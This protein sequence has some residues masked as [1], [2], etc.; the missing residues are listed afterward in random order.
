MKTILAVLVAA[1]SLT[2]QEANKT[3][4][5]MQ[6]I[7]KGLAD[8]KS[9][10]ARTRRAAVLLLGKYSQ[11]PAV[12]AVCD[13]LSDPSP[14]VRQTA[15]V[16]VREK[17]TVAASDSPSMFFVSS[18][19]E[20]SNNPLYSNA[21][22]S[23][24]IK[25]I[26]DDK[27]DI[28][29][30]ASAAISEMNYALM[31]SGTGRTLENFC[32]DLELRKIIINAYSDKDSGVRQN[33]F[34]YYS[35]FRKTVPD[36]VLLKGI[37]D[38][39]RAVKTNALTALL[40]YRS[41][42]V[43]ES[44]TKLMASKDNDIRRT[45]VERMRYHSNYPTV[46]REMKKLLN[47]Q[48][49]I[50][51]GKALYSLV[52]S[53][54]SLPEE[55]VTGILNKLTIE[56]PELGKSIVKTLGSKKGYNNLLNKLSKDNQSPYC[57]SALEVLIRSGHTVFST[58]DLVK[59]M[60]TDERNLLSACVSA[61]SRKKITA[62]DLLPLTESEHTEAREQLLNI[63]YS[64]RNQDERAELLGDLLLDDNESIR[65]RTINRYI[66]LRC[67]DWKQVAENALTD[68]SG[69]VVYETVRALLR[70]RKDGYE[71]LRKKFAE[72]PELKALIIKHAEA[73]KDDFTLKSLM[74]FK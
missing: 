48:D 51:A 56:S 69:G 42:I 22:I 29:R 17:I 59:M 47:D 4:T 49:T 19:G 73:K 37:E 16:T 21:T 5:E 10:N 3:E 12:N 23:A 52:Y 26:G 6:T 40:N 41:K 33:M 54:T 14:E 1:S 35:Y 74:L 38:E 28:R 61:L 32:K 53:K 57:T 63:V 72:Q 15:L 7:I 34:K 68:D 36:T 58:E 67:T 18:S 2:A 50:I 39:N 24:M 44:I 71:I 11:I 8:I 70:N 66:S 20:K 65:S 9:E 46:K 62:E 27:I 25:L 64:L 55:T 43:L 31:L 60:D 30:L 13:A 45:V